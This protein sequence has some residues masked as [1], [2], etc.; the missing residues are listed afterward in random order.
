MFN[1]LRKYTASIITVLL[2]GNKVCQISRAE[3]PCEKKISAPIPGIQGEL[4][5]QDHA[6]KRHVHFLTYEKGWFHLSVR[7][8][9]NLACQIDCLVSEKEKYDEKDFAQG[10]IDGIR[11][12]PF[13]ISGAKVDNAGF[14]GKGLFERGLHFSGTITPGN[15]S[16]SCICD[17]CE[18]NFRIK[19][20]HAGFSNLGY[21]YSESGSQT[22]VVS[23]YIDSAPPA[24]GKPDFEKL[25]KLEAQLPLAK[26]GTSFKYKNSFRCPH[27]GSAYIDFERFPKQRESEYYGNYFYGDE[28]VRFESEKQKGG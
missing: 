15:V 18:K 3:I 24:M 19:S 4:V 28:I 13:F 21:F 5:F 7:V 12:Q 11:F 10:K 14:Q 16:L 27:C 8:H 1:F 2:N 9:Q 25:A 26:D 22:L 6:E 20:F 23:S 17:K